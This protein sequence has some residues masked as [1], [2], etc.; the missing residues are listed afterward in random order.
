MN[1]LFGQRYEAEYEI[2]VRRTNMRPYIRPWLKAQSSHDVKVG[3]DYDSVRVP[4]NL[5]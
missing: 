5:L 3:H 1:G 4:L 2:Q